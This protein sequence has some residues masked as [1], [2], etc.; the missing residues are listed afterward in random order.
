M[1]DEY[2]REKALPVVGPDGTP[3]LVRFRGDERGPKEMSLGAVRPV[4]EGVPIPPGADLVEMTPTDGD[5]LDVKTIHQ[6]SAGRGWKP[7]QV[8]PEKFA[9]NWDRTFGKKDDEALPN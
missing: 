1:S 8:P 6:G 4:I 2:T 7:M 9:S 5:F 3:H